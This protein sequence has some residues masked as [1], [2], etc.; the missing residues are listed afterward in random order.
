[1]SISTID[2]NKV[3]LVIEPIGMGGELLLKA[4]R[5]LGF[6]TVIAT[7]EDVY[8]SMLQGFN[9]MIDDLIFVDFSARE[10]AIETLIEESKN[11]GVSG[12]VVAWE[13]LTDI[14]AEVAHGLNFCGPDATLSRARRNKYFMYRTLA[15]AKCPLPSLQA[16]ITNKDDINQL[17]LEEL[18]FPLVVKP[19]ENAASFGVSVINEIKDL[20]QAFID[21]SQWTHEYPHGIPFSNEI[22][23]QEYIPGQEFSVEGISLSGKYMPWGVTMKFTTPGKARAETGHIFPAPIP[24]FLRDDVLDVAAKAVIALGIT[25][26]ISH[27]EIKLDYE[28]KPRVIESCSRPAGDYIP[29]L[30]ELSTDENPLAIYAKQAV[31]ILPTNFTPAHPKRYSA[32]QFIRPESEGTFNSIEMPSSLAHAEIIES[33]V[34]APF[35]SNVKPGSTNIERLGWAIFISNSKDYVLQAMDELSQRVKV[36]IL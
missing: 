9:D 29:R 5:S 6:H 27:T 22:L 17:P 25:N 11:K 15:E 14:A 10:A 26:G 1:M 13:F 12:V 23:I 8:H 20:P 32:I 34:T 31:D 7:T 24:D 3:I 33:R 28:G 2:S 4:T 19:A 21:A 30:V 36:D 18:E 16:V 35:G